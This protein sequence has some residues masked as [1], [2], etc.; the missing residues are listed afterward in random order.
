MYHLVVASVMD[1]WKRRSLTL[2]SINEM[3]EHHK[4]YHMMCVHGS[5]LF[6]PSNF[7]ISEDSLDGIFT[8]EGS[9]DIGSFVNH[10][11]SNKSN[12]VRK[13]NGANE[14]W[15]G[16]KAFVVLDGPSSP[17]MLVLLEGWGVPKKFSAYWDGGTSRCMVYRKTKY[18]SRGVSLKGIFGPY[19]KNIPK[20]SPKEEILKKGCAPRERC[21][22]PRKVKTSICTTSP[23]LIRDSP[24]T[25]RHIPSGR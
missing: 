9:W 4:W 21:A 7:R 5:S 15:E 24:K 17:P 6:F 11:K 25:I 19:R 14:Y 18:S 22:K 13:G 23:S 1:L 10:E 12:I 20:V 16:D 8:H 2:S 3:D